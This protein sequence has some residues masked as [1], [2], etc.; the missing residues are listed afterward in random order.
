MNA[1][2]VFPPSP[3]VSGMRFTGENAEFR[4]LVAKGAA[5]EL[6]TLGFYRFWLATHIRRHLWSHTQ[7]DGDGLEYLGTGR[8]LMI[9]FLVG[10]AILAPVYVLYALAGLVAEAYQAFASF[11]LAVFYYGFM[12]FAIY[13][14]RR[15]RL[16]RTMWRGV[17]FG[18]DGSGAVYAAKSML[19]GLGVLLTLGFL[20]PWRQA[21]L[22][23]YKMRHSYYGALRG[24][25]AG[26]G[27]GLLRKL[28]W[29]YA[30]ALF[31]AI[32]IPVLGVLSAKDSPLATDQRTIAGA[33][34]VL[35]FFGSLVSLPFALAAFRSGEWQWW[36]DGLRMG[37]VSAGSSLKRGDLVG[38]YWA[39]IG[40]VLAALVVFGALAGGVS[41]LAF[42]DGVP[43]MGAGAPKTVAAIVAL[44]A[45]Y[46]A[47]L[48][49]CTAIIRI[50]T[51]QRVWKAVV[52]STLLI[53]LDK[54]GD[55]VAR[56]DSVT[57]VG[58]GIAD[59]LD[60]LGF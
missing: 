26:A 28:W 4:R 49:C 45:L 19:W 27:G 22:E 13:R 43:V 39:I 44:G 33:L 48:L 11:P 14:G 17:R 29:L 10:V 38:F 15:Y 8:E 6:A 12:Q 34:A 7:I 1:P 32:A 30:L 20:Y 3:P 37:P 5:L 46:L 58:E 42:K 2:T 59:G 24:D 35:L 52:G 25:F 54:A 16:N 41:V 18:M 21:A 60:V 31:V 53:G 47:F 50:Y 51:T 40:L 9:G 55:V 36:I 23:R 57:A 56:D